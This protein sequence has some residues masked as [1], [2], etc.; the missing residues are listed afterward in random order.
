MDAGDA[1]TLIPARC[2]EISAPELALIE[3]ALEDDVIP[4]MALD[5]ILILLEAL[6]ARLDGL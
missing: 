4:V 2:P 6:E 3:S 5:D 1:A